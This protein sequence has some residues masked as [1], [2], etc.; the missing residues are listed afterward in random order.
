MGDKKPD[1]YTSSRQL[2]EIYSIEFNQNNSNKEMV[3]YQSYAAEMKYFF[4]DFNFIIMQPFIKMTDGA[5]D[6][7]CPVESA[8]WGEFKGIIT[9]QGSFGVSHAGVIDAYKINY[10]GM[11]IVELYLGIVKELS[12]KGF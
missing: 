2:S 10:K 4:S 1:F 5:N 6:G 9:T 11:D 3:Y 12:K 8:K 7:L